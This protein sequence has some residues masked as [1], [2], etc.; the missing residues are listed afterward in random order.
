MGLSN[1]Q[2]EYLEQLKERFTNSS[3]FILDLQRRQQ[4]TQNDKI[5]QKLS[6]CPIYAQ[7]QLVYLHKPS[8]T[9]L[10]GNSKKFTAKYVGPFVIHQLLDST[11]V[12][13][14]DL[15]GRILRDVFHFNRLKP[16]FMRASAGQN[17]TNLQ[18]LKEALQKSDNNNDQCHLTQSNC[19][20]FTDEC[21]SEIN[22]DD[23]DFLY[24]AHADP[25]DLNNCFQNLSANNGMAATT[26][27]DRD[28]QLRLLH[29]LQSAPSQDS[30]Y[31]IEKA[32][33]RAGQLIILLSLQR[34]NKKY[35][36][37]FDPSTDVNGPEIV[38]T[39]FNN[40][41]IRITGSQNKFLTRMH[42]MLQVK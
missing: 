2:A 35:S 21:G 22:S 16:A 6:K 28:R 37:W 7:G 31:T 4:I 13:L 23:G 19:Y 26:I 30:Q 5:S 36:F 14:A 12:L 24:S 3:K 1:S 10:T 9:S 20:S 18:K 38:E 29:S 41:K 25:V 8:S 27:L 39:I 34:D 11:H 15:K 17:I 40:G 42:M 33:F 32:R